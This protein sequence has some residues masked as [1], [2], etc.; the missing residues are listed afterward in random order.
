MINK[1]R[2]KKDVKNLNLGFSELEVQKLV[3]LTNVKF[4]ELYLNFLKIAGKK[5]NVFDHYFDN[6]EGL[7]EL[8]IKIKTKIENSDVNNFNF[9]IWCFSYSQ[10]EEEYYYFEKDDVKNPIVLCYT[11]KTYPIDNGWNYRLGYINKKSKFSNF[12][13]SKTNDKYDFTLL[14]NIERYFLLVIFSPFLL[15]IYIFVEFGKRIK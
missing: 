4:P 6:I 5:S 8:Q 14:G 15:F 1:I 11:N 12:I 7:I 9:K 13:N 10:E 2:F 3:G